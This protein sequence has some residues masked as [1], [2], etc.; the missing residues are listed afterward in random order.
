MDMDK[1]NRLIDEFVESNQPHRLYEEGNL[2]IEMTRDVNDDI[3][4]SDEEI[5]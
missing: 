4:F 3:E 1:I 5:G 2:H